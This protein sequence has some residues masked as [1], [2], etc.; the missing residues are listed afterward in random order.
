MNK[1]S[2]M[3]I[4][5]ILKCFYGILASIVAANLSVIASYL[6]FT[7]PISF[8]TPIVLWL[9]LSPSLTIIAIV[10][11]ERKST[12]REQLALFF[13]NFCATTIA[14]AALICL[15][16]ITAF[17]WIILLLFPSLIFTGAI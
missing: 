3:K 2:K 14:L 7:S 15:G 5:I 12:N 9:S 13:Y 16:F 17:G 8:F 1:T 4:R 10:V 6:L 11:F